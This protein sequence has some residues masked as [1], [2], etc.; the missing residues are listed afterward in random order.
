[1][2]NLHLSSKKYCNTYGSAGAAVLLFPLIIFAALGYL[3]YPRDRSKGA[4]YGLIIGLIFDTLLYSLS[5]YF[6]LD[7]MK[8]DYNDNKNR[9]NKSRV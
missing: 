4:W 5:F 7:L 2:N 1:M 8:Y 9:K 6:I 3:F